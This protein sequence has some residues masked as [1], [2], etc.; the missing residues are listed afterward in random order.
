MESLLASIVCAREPW[1]ERRVRKGR[2]PS[3][4]K[5]FVPLRFLSRLQATEPEEDVVQL[6]SGGVNGLSVGVM[7]VT[8][9]C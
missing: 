2:I 5:R 3:E 7:K 4:S 9:V 8:A 1:S 6:L